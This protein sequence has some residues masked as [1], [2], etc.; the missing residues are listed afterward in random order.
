MSRTTKSPLALARAAL[1]TAE[2]VVPPYSCKHS[3]KDFTQPQLL[4]LLLLKQFFKIGYRDVVA[5][6][7]E[8]SDLRQALGLTKVPHFTAI[9]KA[10]VR[11]L[12]KSRSS[13]CSTPRWRSPAAATPKTRRSSSTSSPST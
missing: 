2:Q 11:L 6:V 8:W 5:W 4:A 7:A 3:R 10:G 1:A 12:K 13:P 9:Q